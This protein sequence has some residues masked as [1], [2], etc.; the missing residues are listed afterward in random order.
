MTPENEK[1]LL[2]A[3][4]DR[5]F[6][7]VCYSPDGKSGVF[8]PQTTLLQFAK[9]TAIS[10]ADYKHQATPMNPNGSLNAAYQFSALVDD[11]PQVS[12]EFV[13]STEMVSLTFEKIAQGAN[14]DAKQ[15]PAQKATYD[16]AMAFLLE[17]SSIPNFKGPPTVSTGPSA[18]AKAYDE[19]QTAYVSAFTGYRVAQNG[20]DLS[21]PK[22]QRDFNAVAPMLQLNIDKAWNTW[23]RQG[24][25]NVEEATNA[26]VAT[27][28]DVV[29]AVIADAQKSVAPDKWQTPPL[30]GSRWLLSYPLPGD[31]A[32][33]NS[34]ASEFK[35]SSNYLNTSSD[36]KSNSYG[37]KT[38]FGLGLWSVS[39]GAEHSDSEQ[40][41]HMDA[42]NVSISAKL[43]LVRIMRPW[44]NTLLLRTDGWWL[45]GQPAG[46]IS[47]GALEG[48]TK[49]MLPLIPVAFVVMSD[50]TIKADFSAADKKHIESAT[51]GAASVGWGP[52]S[53]SA[54]YAHSDSKDMA[55][56][57]FD[58]GGVHI[59][60]MQIV[61]WVSAITPASPPMGTPKPA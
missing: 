13:P 40:N 46:A 45:K 31:W 32:D 54:H 38:A 23:V 41:F 18:I 7:A 28:N 50:V 9:N 11:I 34:G 57:S 61:A 36:S 2:Q 5:I 14:T 58:E 47:N 48:N 39:G 12:V 4:Y 24:K 33:G 25:N 3:L 1:Q 27:I 35:L 21:K 19:N 60:G 59:P 51:S 20:Y 15:D 52:F 22:D 6:D 55:K 10:A 37:A 30:G 56:A 8:N 26:M 42:S 29:T 53:V 49:G 43:K 16:A 44:L 17:T